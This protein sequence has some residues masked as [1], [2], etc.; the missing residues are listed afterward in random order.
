MLNINKSDPQ[1]YYFRGF[2]YVNG[3]LKQALEHVGQNREALQRALEDFEQ[4]ERLKPHFPGDQDR[5]PRD[6]ESVGR[7]AEVTA[8]WSSA[9]ITSGIG[10]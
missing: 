8:L 10:S 7:S 3:D 9:Q 1:L 5:D 2:T 4:V 6:Q